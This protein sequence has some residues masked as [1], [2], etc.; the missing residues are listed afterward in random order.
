MINLYDLEQQLNVKFQ[1]GSDSAPSNNVH[2]STADK[3]RSYAKGGYKI[4]IGN[5][6]RMAQ[7]KKHAGKE[8]VLLAQV[9]A[10]THGKCIRT[11]HAVK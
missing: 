4:V 5:N 6:P 8:V 7:A 9:N 11:I 1:W 10:R 2:K 3:I